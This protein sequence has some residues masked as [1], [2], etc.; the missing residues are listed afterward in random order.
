MSANSSVIDFPSQS[1]NVS[2]HAYHKRWKHPELFDKG[3]IPLPALF[4]RYYANL[5]PHSLTTGEA[6]FVIHLMEFK[7]DSNEPFPS[8]KTIAKRMGV[9]DKLARR[10]AQS[11]EIKKFLVRKQRIGDTNL[12]DLTPLFDAIVRAVEKDKASSPNR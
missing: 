1:T 4:L 12:F 7:W 11:L 3:Y 8:Y 6:M 10:H 5:K 9:S 2:E